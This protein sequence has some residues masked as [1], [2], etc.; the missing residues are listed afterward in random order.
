MYYLMTV[1]LLYVLFS[2]YVG[3]LQANFSVPYPSRPP[4][5]YLGFPAAVP[6]R[7]PDAIDPTAPGR[8][9]KLTD[10]QR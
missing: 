3:S 1:Y 8:C 6:G 7:S 2:F 10:V 4:N 5:G 9:E